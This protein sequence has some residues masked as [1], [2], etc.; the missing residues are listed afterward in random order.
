MDAVMKKKE[1]PLLCINATWHQGAEGV[2]GRKD[3]KQTGQKEGKDTERA[4]TLPKSRKTSVKT[5]GRRKAETSSQVK[6]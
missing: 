1:C 6:V 3:V 4:D 2:W 5:T